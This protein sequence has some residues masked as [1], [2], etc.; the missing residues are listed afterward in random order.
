MSSSGTPNDNKSDEDKSVSLPEQKQA[1]KDITAKDSADISSQKSPGKSPGKSSD[2]VTAKK[3]KQSP[4]VKKAARSRFSSFIL[5]MFT[6]VLLG[7]AGGG[8][9]YWQQLQQQLAKI[10]NDVGDHERKLDNAIPRLDQVRVDIQGQNTLIEQ[11]T[12]ENQLQKKQLEEFKTTQQTMLQSMQNVFDITHRNQRQWLL[13]EVS[14]LLSLANQ[15]LI[16]SRDIKTAV[17]ALS[18]ANN[19]LHDLSDPSLLTLR[20]EIADEIATL[21]MLKLP[22]IN[23][24]AFSLDNAMPLISRLPF[25]SE[26]QKLRDSTDQAESVE[27]AELDSDSFF[28]P[29]WKRIKSLVSI[30]KHNR[31]I[32]TTETALEKHDI[33]NQLQFRIEASRLALINKNTK[34]FNHEILSAVEILTLYYD[35]QDNRVVTLIN[36]LASYTE[37][38]LLPDLPDITGSWKKLQQVIAVNDAMRT[39][40]PASNAANNSK[41]KPVK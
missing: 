20:K 22:D 37:L 24:M 16:I 26:Q 12:A 9:Y 7:I 15:R 40:E 11:L 5:S 34:V 23:K 30:K 18:A 25:K 10:Q 4:A 32:K 14:Y 35:Q 21:N 19:R 6:L 8:Y 27:L 13:S 3:A 29:V 33:D 38:N 41:G 2:D 17:A 1:E 36:E 39:L 28:S 31:E